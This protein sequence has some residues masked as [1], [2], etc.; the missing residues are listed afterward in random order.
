MVATHRRH[1]AIEQA[2]NERSIKKGKNNNITASFTT[3]EVNPRQNQLV[4][5]IINY[6]QN[7]S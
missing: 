2:V 7:S 1:P 3:N 4:D 5:A 6:V